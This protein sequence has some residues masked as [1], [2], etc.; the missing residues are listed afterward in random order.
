[1]VLDPQAIGAGCRGAQLTT[2]RQLCRKE[3]HRFQAAIKSEAPVTVA[4]TQEAALF[5][6]VAEEAGGKAPI[7]YA[8]V[9]ETA[10]W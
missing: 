4:C 8:N 1:M 9:R 2:A 6:E 10:G 7:A 5:G 3:L